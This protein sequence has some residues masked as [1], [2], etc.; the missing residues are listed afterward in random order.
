MALY[1]GYVVYYGLSTIH[2]H[3][4]F[5]CTQ[6]PSQVPSTVVSGGSDQLRAGPP[7]SLMKT[8]EGSYKRRE[9]EER[10]RLTSELHEIE[11]ESLVDSLLLYLP[12]FYHGSFQ[13]IYMEG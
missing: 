5:I 10:E 12:E 1:A 2:F 4:V 13:R 7:S 11:R 8:T 9:E 3:S 6:S